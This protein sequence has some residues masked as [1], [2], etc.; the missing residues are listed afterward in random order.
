MISF[1]FRASGV[2]TLFLLVS[3]SW[4]ESSPEDREKDF[5]V[6]DYD[7]SNLTVTELFGGPEDKGALDYEEMD[8]VSGLVVSRRNPSFLWTHND[9]GDENRIFLLRNDGTW[10]N[11]FYLPDVTNRDW[12]DIAIGPGPQEGINYLYIAEIGDNRAQFQL[13]YIYRFPEPD[14]TITLHDYPVNNVET[15]TF[16][17]PDNVMMDAE[18]LLVDPWTRDI[19]IITKREY[20]ATVYRLPYPQSTTETITA[21][22]YGVLPFIMAVGGDIS[23]DG[24]NIIVKTYD[25]VYLWQRNEG[26]TMAAAFMRKPLRLNYIPEPQG[27]AVGFTPDGN[28]YYTLSE[29]RDGIWPRLYF[30]SRKK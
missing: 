11:T 25:R 14:V 1:R 8:E 24:R 3:C 17:Y 28:G 29:V 18:T 22:L 13:K 30:Y 26:E 20:P 19:Y 16:V 6:A 27:E 23:A 7:M 5:F 9:S 21:Q 12:E 10:A 2:M 15:I 4:F